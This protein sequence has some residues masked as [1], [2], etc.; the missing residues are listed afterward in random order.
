MPA[1]LAGVRCGVGNIPRIGKG[2]ACQIERLLCGLT[3]VKLCLLF[4]GLAVHGALCESEATPTWP[5]KA[6]FLSRATP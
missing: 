6:W 2:F 3:S 5:L 4:P 1:T